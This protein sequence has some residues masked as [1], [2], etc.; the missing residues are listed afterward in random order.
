MAGV[1]KASFTA[2]VFLAVLVA[3][4]FAWYVKGDLEMGWLVAMPAVAAVTLVAALIGGLFLPRGFP[5]VAVVLASLPFGLMIAWFAASTPN[6]WPVPPDPE[7]M[8]RSGE[9]ASDLDRLG[10]VAHAALG[11]P[12]EVG[13]AMVDSVPGVRT[14]VSGRLGLERRPASV[15]VVVAFDV[16]PAEPLRLRLSESG[17]VVPVSPMPDVSRIRVARAALVRRYPQ[18]PLV[19]VGGDGTFQP[20]ALLP[21]RLMHGERDWELSL[22]RVMAGNEALP[23]VR[24][25]AHDEVAS[26]LAAALREGGR[27]PESIATY[28]RPSDDRVLY[29]QDAGFDFQ[30]RLAGG[31]RASLRV[32]LE[33]DSLA[34]RVVGVQDGPAR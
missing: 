6:N 27:R 17:D 20:G 10:S 21:L 5:R 16:G 11:L 32:E 22:V 25:W 30:A 31:G 33:A 28:Y 3:V 34:F 9:L 13:H 23:E 18:V 8:R 12:V 26:R 29:F 14:K 19:E 7:L 24:R 4:T 1:V 15:L 2:V